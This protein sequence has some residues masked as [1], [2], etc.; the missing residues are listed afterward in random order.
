MPDFFDT[1]L[2]EHVMFGQVLG[3]MSHKMW[4]GC[5][6]VLTDMLMLRN[7]EHAGLNTAH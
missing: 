6:R 7:W 5:A 4:L 3:D 1:S 2:F